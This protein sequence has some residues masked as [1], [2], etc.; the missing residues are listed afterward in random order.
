MEGSVVKGG[1][2]V[3][4]DSR[5][6]S[7]GSLLTGGRAETGSLLAGIEEEGQPMPSRRQESPVVLGGGC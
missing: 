1:K 5:V 6:D 2:L 7:G 4:I 3:L